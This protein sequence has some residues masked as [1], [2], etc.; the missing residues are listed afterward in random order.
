MADSRF[1]QGDVLVVAVERLP[2][3]LE[4]VAREDGT[5]VPALG[6]ATGHRLAI[7]EPHA[8]LLE[9]LGERFLHVLGT[10]ARLVDGE[11]GEHGEHDRIVLPTGR[12]QVIH[13][14]KYQPAARPRVVAG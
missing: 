11:H 3:R 1:R 4:L 12:C 6:E 2:E 9:D 5:V 14:R 13:Q 7:L 8:G 10:P